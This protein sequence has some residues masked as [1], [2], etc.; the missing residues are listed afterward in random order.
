MERF[1]NRPMLNAYPDSVGSKLGDMVELLK[2]PELAG[3]FSSFYVLPSLYH[4]DLDRG[5]CVIDYDLNEELATQADLD[6]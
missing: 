3:T 5:F 6:A 1:D 4:S 2:R